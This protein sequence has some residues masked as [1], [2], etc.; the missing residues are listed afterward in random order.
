MKGPPRRSQHRHRGM[1]TALSVEPT[2]LGSPRPSYLPP[3]SQ[4]LRKAGGVRGHPA[5][6]PGRSRRTCRRCSHKS[7]EQLDAIR[8]LVDHLLRCE[9]RDD[10]SARSGLPSR[11]G[12]SRWE[13][14]VGAAL[15]WHVG[16]PT[17]FRASPMWNW[18]LP[19]STA[20]RTGRSLQPP[21]RFRL[22]C[23]FR[24]KDSSCQPRPEGERVAAPGG[25]LQHDGLYG[26][27]RGMSAPGLAPRM[28]DRL[29]RNGGQRDEPLD[30]TATPNGSPRPPIRVLPS[31]FPP[32]VARA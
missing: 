10:P 14:C 22:G 20:R 15:G 25:R 29:T 5:Q 9:P 8:P 19:P 23:A 4:R 18:H 21:R 1:S 24:G 26:C 3:S 13:E 28:V 31:S 16:L 30:F 17:R 27:T 32:R 11:R 6:Q 12:Q 7:L 2:R